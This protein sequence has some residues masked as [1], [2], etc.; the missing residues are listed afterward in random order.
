MTFRKNLSAC[1]S[2]KIWN[3][4][5]DPITQTIEKIRPPAQKLTTGILAAVN[6]VSEI[7]P[8]RDLSVV[9]LWMEFQ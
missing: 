7:P 2:K 4:K 6:D 3:N 5:S 9:H 1:F 8:V